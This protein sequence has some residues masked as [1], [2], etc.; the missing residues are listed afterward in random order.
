MAILIDQKPLYKTLP[1]GQDIVFSVSDSTIVANNF[2]VKFVAEVY[3]SNSTSSLNTLNRIA[4][5]KTT[6]N[7]AGVGIFSMQPVLESFVKPDNIGTDLGNGSKYKTVSYSDTTPHPIHLID[8][9]AL[10]ENA[11]KYFM[12]EFSLEFSPTIDGVVTIDQ[13]NKI[14]SD[15]YLFY[16]GYLNYDDVLNQTGNDYGYNLS[17]FN[18]VMNSDSGKFLSNAP[19]TQFARISDYGTLSF[20]NFLSTSDYS[21]QVGSGTA[22]DKRVKKIQI[23]L[24][25]SSNT[26]LSTQDVVATI[27]NGSYT[28][29]NNFSY[30]RINYFGVFPANL[31]GWST[32]FALN[33]ANISYYTIQAL[34]DD[35]E[36]ISQLYRINIITD[37][38]KGFEG[39]R[40]TWL[41][42]YGVWDYYTFTKKSVRS[43]Q[44]NRTSYTQ[45]GGTWNE[46]TYKINGFSGGKKNFRVN[47]KELIT[48]NTD[49]LVDAD[50]IWFEDLINSPEVY[51]LNGFS[52]DSNGMVNK[53]VEPV[54]VTTSSYTRKTKANDKLIQYT[55]ELEKSK[56]KR[57]QS[58]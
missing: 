12:I 31:S 44:T 47:S 42:P 37:D 58:A 26:L 46:S 18:K 2:N 55:F 32:P 5:L 15:V 45:L 19:I 20:F 34:D 38:C 21:F 50:A 40:L 25:N 56:N 13:T 43:L 54:T 3:V 16:N 17:S 23:K 53:Y 11:I 39:I 24:Y 28:V 41:N 4:V 29:A 7:N 8:Q 33:K 1:V 6:P 48:V 9:Y 10:A 51:I 49:Y 35:D 22:T 57:I 27:S 52:S 36:N 30:T 14:S